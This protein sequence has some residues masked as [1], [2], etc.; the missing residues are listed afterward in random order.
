MK[1]ARDR[2]MKGDDTHG[3]E[4]QWNNG[5]KD[6]IMDIG[7][8]WPK[9]FITKVSDLVRISWVLFSALLSLS[10]LLFF[11]FAVDG[12]MADDKVNCSPFGGE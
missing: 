10:L 1:T 7:N 4:N 8:Y 12:W 6:E 5:R 3:K 9:F 2:M 11:L